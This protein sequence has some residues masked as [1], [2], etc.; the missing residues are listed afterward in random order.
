MSKFRF[1]FL[2]LLFVFVSNSQ[3]QQSTETKREIWPEFDVFLPVKDQFRLIFTV[4]SQKASETK[5]GLEGHVS[6]S[7]DYFIKNRI[8]LRAGYRYGFSLDASDPFRE[9]RISTD[10]SFHKPLPRDFVLSD[11]NRQEF[12]WVN[13]DFSTRFRNRVMLEKTFAINER[14]LV[15][16]GSGEIFYDSR[17]STFN[18][19]RLIAGT[20]IHF[21]KHEVWLLNVRR[22]QILN[23]Y[24]LWQ[25]DTRSQSKNLHALG[26][27]FELHY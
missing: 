12:R 3:A 25:R 14:S 20:E 2:V 21:R 13:G 27:T 26:I 24:Y 18:R 16:Y 4:G 22:Q 11:R 15:P 10:Q 9:H 23:L 7:L 19:V 6:A 8:T 1:S 5:D 17:F